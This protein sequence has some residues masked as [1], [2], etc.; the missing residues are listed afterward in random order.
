MS[1]KDGL[2]GLLCEMGLSPKGRPRVEPWPLGAQVLAQL[3]WGGSCPRKAMTPNT[4]SLMAFPRLAAAAIVCLAFEPRLLACP[5][6][7]A[8]HSH[9]GISAIHLYLLESPL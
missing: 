1:S 8:L 5:Y 3:H 4:L 6:P 7:P 2:I 9:T